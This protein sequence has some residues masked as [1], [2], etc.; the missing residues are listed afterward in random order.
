M[1]MAGRGVE[2]LKVWVQVS[3]MKGLG[4]KTNVALD[5]DS[6]DGEKKKSQARST[7]ESQRRLDVLPLGGAKR[8][9]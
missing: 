2:W 9:V 7:R 5:D 4:C 6:G 8:G 3:Y 1:L